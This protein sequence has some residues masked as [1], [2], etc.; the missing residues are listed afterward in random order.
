MVDYNSGGFSQG[1]DGAVYGN[2]ASTSSASDYNSWDWKQIMAAVN[3]GA[4]MAGTSDAGR[5]AAV[6]DPA[7]LVAAGNSFYHA[8]LVLEMV[9]KSLDDQSKALAGDDA[10]WRG[11]AAQSFLTAMK[12]FSEQVSAVAG[13]LSGGAS[14]LNSV[15][16]QLVA[17]GNQLAYAQAKIRAIDAWYASEAQRLGAT[18]MGN[19]LIPV[20]K[21]PEVVRLMNRDMRWV[22]NDLAGKYQVTVDAVR[23]PAPVQPPVKGPGTGDGPRMP[24]IGR[25]P[26]SLPPPAPFPGGSGPSVPDPL[27][28]SVPGLPA[29]PVPA[30]AGAAGPLPFPGGAGTGGPGIPGPGAAP[31]PF[32]GGGTV[33]G[34]SSPEGAGPAVPNAFPG[35]GAMPGLPAP[36]SPGTG[37]PLPFPG[38]AG[39]GGG[40][41]GLGSDP[42]GALLGTGGGLPLPFPGMTGMTG[43]TGTGR[44][45]PGL[46]DGTRRGLPDAGA[47]SPFPGMSA[48][49]ASELP[50]PSTSS[51]GPLSP[52]PG[53]SAPGASELP[54]PSTSSAGP[55]SPFPGMSA[56]GVSELPSP[57]TSPGAG[58]P[59]FTGTGGPVGSGTAGLDAAGRPL[60]VDAPSAALPGGAGQTGDAVAAGSS[61]PMMP[62]S[63]MMPGGAAAGARDGE[64]SDA[65]GLL[66]PDE[67]PWTEDAEAAA[68]DEIG[69]PDGTPAADGHEVTLRP[70]GAA[71][72]LPQAVEAAATVASPTAA[73]A[74]AGQSAEHLDPL[75]LLEAGAAAWLAE[76]S[77]GEAVTASAVAEPRAV[78]EVQAATAAAVVSATATAA[79]VASGGSTVGVADTSGVGGRRTA[80]APGGGKPAAAVSALEPTAGEATDRPAGPAGHAAAAAQGA[81]GPSGSSS[82]AAAGQPSNTSVPG[83]ARA[84]E[85]ARMPSG[86]PAP[87]VLDP[88]ARGGTAAAP[89]GIGPSRPGTGSSGPS[90]A[91]PEAGRPA[92]HGERAAPEPGSP[93]EVTAWDDSV[94]LVPLLWRSLGR[95]SRED[96]P[97]EERAAGTG[98]GAQDADGPSAEQEP[99]GPVLTSWRPSPV[100]AGTDGT[101]GTG[102][103]GALE[104][105]PRSGHWE[106]GGD[107]PAEEPA[108]EAGVTGADHAEESGTNRI[109]QLLAGSD[110]QWGS[111]DDDADG[112]AD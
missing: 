3:G 103:T 9:A 72:D 99:D 26:G 13:V 46:D 58:A 4:A 27:H 71:G 8:Q 57:S 29:T 39:T 32:P 65:S 47:P 95:S 2:P 102:G 81:P 61:G 5:A 34:L 80:A 52:F 33:P 89:A 76:E 94:S 30:P 93:E 59:T 96:R 28:A 67:A 15:P 86:A 31:L 69:A 90:T 43:M 82:A 49:G 22:L 75:G 98:E 92:R 88:S 6:A 107:E 1:D 19:G 48:P 77:S 55:L 50:S 37:A 105:G 35:G 25:G 17:N 44:G 70:S 66:V 109:A 7:T 41:P 42:A 12:G 21:K 63:P 53:M 74:H 16:R 110:T 14:G 104:E 20:S 84:V 38:G 40:L 23:S 64:R 24:D 111:W 11:E 54:S 60:P 36:D 62:M 68:D 73:E 101:G 87:A 10:P 112:V 51:A 79:G 97:W 85:P 56:P 106:P 91:G 18:A 100:R 83:S 45:A 78:A 108:A